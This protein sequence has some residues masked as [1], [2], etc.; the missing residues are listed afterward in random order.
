MNNLHEDSPKVKSQDNASKIGTPVLQRVSRLFATTLKKP[1]LSIDNVSFVIDI[2]SR[3]RDFHKK[4]DAEIKRFMNHDITKCFGASKHYEYHFQYKT[5]FDIQHGYLDDPNNN[6]I[7]IEC[8]PN[9]CDFMELQPIFFVFGCLKL[10]SIRFTRFDWAIDYPEKLNPSLF[11]DPYKR[12]GSIYFKEGI[13]TLYLGSKQSDNQLRIYN[14]AIDLQRKHDFIYTGDLWRVEAQ[15][16]GSENLLNLPNPFVNLSYFQDVDTI[17]IASKGYASLIQKIGISAFRSECSRQEWRT[18]QKKYL[19]KS[20]FIKSPS[21]VFN[22][23]HYEIFCQLCDRMIESMS[24]DLIS[25]GQLNHFFAHCFLP[26]GADRRPVPVT[27]CAGAR[28]TA[29]PGIKS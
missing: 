24:N 25:R 26:F 5:M 28:T 23:D 20:E 11:F 7:R 1:R 16:R 10:Q 14:K 3:N 15:C 21:D 13:E 6:N 18:I 9:Y 4:F 8:N 29:A 27:S 2:P 22:D 12:S 17:D 19:K